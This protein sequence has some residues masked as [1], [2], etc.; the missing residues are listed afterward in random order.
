MKYFLKLMIPSVVA[1]I[2]ATGVVLGLAG[3]SWPKAIWAGSVVLI[4]FLTVGF[5][6]TI[7]GIAIRRHTIPVEKTENPP[8]GG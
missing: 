4:I 8:K 3:A 6:L 5:T 1:V 7:M 2:V